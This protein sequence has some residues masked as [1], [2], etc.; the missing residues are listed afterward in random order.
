M[1]E[2]AKTVEGSVILCRYS[3]GVKL[4]EHLK[5]AKLSE[6]YKFIP[7]YFRVLSNSDEPPK[8]LIGADYIHFQSGEAIGEIHEKEE[9]PAKEKPAKKEAKKP[10]LKVKNSEGKIVEVA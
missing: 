10:P 2:K 4:N 9:K 5:E 1:M 8:E 6:E 7:G 3:K